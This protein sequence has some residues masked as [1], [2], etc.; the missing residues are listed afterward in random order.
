MSAL[1]HVP[2]G[3]GEVLGDS[4]TRHVELLAERDGLH[5]TIARFGV[6]Q[7]GA[8]PHVHTATP[9]SST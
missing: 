2:R 1:R 5:A 8:D 6:G 9:T 3:G 4:D 7:D